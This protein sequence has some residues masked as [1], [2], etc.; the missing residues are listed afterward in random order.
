[1]AENRA[2]L[3]FAGAVLLVVGGGLAALA[4]SG[5]DPP[6]MTGS[7]TERSSASVA[8]PVPLSAVAAAL[9]VK[10]L[11]DLVLVR[12]RIHAGGLDV[13][14]A[15]LPPPSFRRSDLVLRLA[16]L[17]AC[18][19]GAFLS[20]HTRDLRLPPTFLSL[21]PRALGLYTRHLR[22]GADP[23]RLI[24]PRIEPPRAGPP[25]EQ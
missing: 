19:G 1:M 13:A 20:L 14:F 17:A 22:L 11:G 4:R 6:A 18:L 8:P 16:L 23:A 7:A 12:V 15:G 21:R 2:K 9:A 3:G 10:A 5:G 24:S 25:A